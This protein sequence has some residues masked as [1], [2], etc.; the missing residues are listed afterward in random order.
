MPQSAKRRAENDISIEDT[1]KRLR[2]TLVLTLIGT[3]TTSRIKSDDTDHGASPSDS[4][5]FSPDATRRT[6]RDVSPSPP[7]R[8][9]ELREP[10]HLEVDSDQAESGD[11]NTSE[12]DASEESDYEDELSD[13]EDDGDQYDDEEDENHEDHPILEGRRVAAGP[14]RELACYEDFPSLPDDFEAH[15]SDEEHE[16]EEEIDWHQVDDDQEYR[17]QAASFPGI[18]IRE[19]VSQTR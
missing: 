11:D 2:P 1:S 8:Q 10:A 9:V 16:D 12:G 13:E 18:G 19:A 17:S 14:A 6:Q 15:P 7:M 4:I 3:P 5:I